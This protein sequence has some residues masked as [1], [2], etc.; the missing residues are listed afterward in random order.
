MNKSSKIKVANVIV[1]L[2]MGGIE[3]L[4]LNL[5]A[6]LDR[7]VFDPVV[8]CIDGGGPLEEEARAAG[9]PVEIVGVPVR[10]F[11]K[12]VSAL[13]KVFGELRP[14]VIHANPGMAA[15]FAAPKGVPVISQ[16]H[17]MLWGRGK[18]SLMIDRYLAR[19]TTYIV[20]I[21]EAIARNTERKIG[22]K[23]GSIRV[24]Y[25]GVDLDKVVRLSRA[26][27][28]PLP[29][30]GLKVVFLGRLA[31]EKA[32]D[33]L[34][35]AWPEVARSY[36]EAR[37]FFIGDGDKRE[38]WEKLAKSLGMSADF[39]GQ[40]NNPYPVLK[41][42]DLFVLPSR[43]GPFELVAVEAMAL[44]LPCVVSDA[45][46][47]PEVVGDA[48]VK[49]RSENAAGCS[50]AIIGLLK[51]AS[52]RSEYSEL[53]RQRAQVFTIQKMAENYGKLYLEALDK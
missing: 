19:R 15:R 2:S 12:A 9:V 6:H 31:Y 24:I 53:A 26:R 3:R 41:Q 40:I 17:S 7:E 35:K 21:S 20:A 44:G 29:G 32:G 16:Y 34:I 18:A 13:K 51:E 5:C 10:N 37:L 52:H 38:E 33:V 39:L 22:L 27:A 50:A 30:D 25:N 45:G 36:P 28:E 14:D 23:P 8:V 47:I 4:T 46:G 42:A 49:F 11:P 43:E 1:D 48:A